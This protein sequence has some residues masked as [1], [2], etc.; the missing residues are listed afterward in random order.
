M[1]KSTDLRVL[2]WL[3]LFLVCFVLFKVIG[4]I[5]KVVNN[6]AVAV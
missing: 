5:E 4:K 3:W 1:G 6:L 2:R